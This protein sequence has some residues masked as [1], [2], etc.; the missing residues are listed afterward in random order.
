MTVFIIENWG[1]FLNFTLV[2]IF[3]WI[4]ECPQMVQKIKSF[5]R[6]PFIIQR[7]IDQFRR[8][9]DNNLE[10]MEKLR[11]I[12]IHELL[13][14]EHL[15]KIYSNAKNQVFYGYKYIGELEIINNSKSLRGKIYCLSLNPIFGDIQNKNVFIKEYVAED[16][17]FDK[18]INNPQVFIFL[19]IGT[20]KETREFLEDFNLKSIFCIS[21]NCDC[22]LMEPYNLLKIG[23]DFFIREL[24]MNEEINMILVGFIYRR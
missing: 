11:M 6:T 22:V 21:E 13:Y 8:F 5:E 7:H 12:Q 1:L 24:V 2:S 3:V 15:A 10:K 4:F 17:I 9:K 19:P 20:I 23:L 18:M 14:Y 16:F